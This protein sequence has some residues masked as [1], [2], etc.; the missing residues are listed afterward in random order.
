MTTYPP[1]RHL[2]KSV[3][4]CGVLHS[5]HT[6]PALRE[7]PENVERAGLQVCHVAWDLPA[8]AAS[9]ERS[10]TIDQAGLRARIELRS[11]LRV[12]LLALLSTSTLPERSQNVK[13]AGLWVQREP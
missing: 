5:G 9:S 3:R 2:K 12:G 6:V 10:E 1:P 8:L 13:R 4:E 11:W 7:H